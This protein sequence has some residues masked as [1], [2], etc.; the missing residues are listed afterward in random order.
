MHEHLDGFG[1]INMNGR[2]YDPMLSRFLSPDPFVQAPGIAM[3]YNRYAYCLNNPFL[4]TD[5]TGNKWYDW[6]N[7]GY[8][9][10]Q[11]WE[12]ADNFAKW[13]DDTDW[14]PSSGNIGGG[15]NSSKDPYA[16]ADIN[17]YRMFDTRNEQSVPVSF[18]V[19]NYNFDTEFD[20]GSKIDKLLLTESLDYD[21][22]HMI[23]NEPMKRDF[24]Q[25]MDRLSARPLKVLSINSWQK[26]KFP[27]KQSA[28]FP[29]PRIKFDPRSTYVNNR[30]VGLFTKIWGVTKPVLIYGAQTGI[31]LYQLFGT[32][33]PL[34]FN[35][36]DFELLIDDPRY[37]KTPMI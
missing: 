24:I 11:F 20:L 3:G 34:I 13:A 26:S 31:E 8:V 22:D 18:S 10:D 15:V 1:L 4:Y 32:K 21:L 36:L 12:G 19:P 23:S 29:Y 25:L 7:P 27:T 14:F 28:Y 33:A 17:G 2:V 6:L 35:I 5:P 37:R 16:Y 30:S 9:W